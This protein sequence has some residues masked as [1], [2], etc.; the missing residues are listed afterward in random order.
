MFFVL[1]AGTASVSDVEQTGEPSP[2]SEVTAAPSEGEDWVRT[3]SFFFFPSPY[4]LG[5]S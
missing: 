4:L 2:K 5:R 3:M 1:Q